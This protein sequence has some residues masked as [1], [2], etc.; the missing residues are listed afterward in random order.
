MKADIDLSPFSTVEELAQML[1][2]ESPEAAARVLEC[3]NLDEVRQLLDIRANIVYQK[4]FT[5]G[6]FCGQGTYTPP[7]E[8]TQ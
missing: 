5:P 3:A 7:D 4:A 2:N 6:R 1:K 8:E